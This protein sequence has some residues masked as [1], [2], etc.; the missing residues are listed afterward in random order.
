M[1]PLSKEET[2]LEILDLNLKEILYLSLEKSIFLN[3]IYLN[4]LNSFKEE[5]T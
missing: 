2:I 3:K 1:S 4:I 5:K